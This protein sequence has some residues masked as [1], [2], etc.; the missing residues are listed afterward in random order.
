MQRLQTVASLHLAVSEARRAGHRVGL[1]PTMGALHDGHSTLIATAAKHCDVVITTLF[2]NP[3]QFGPT[4]DFS[5]YPRLL[6]ADAAIAERAGSRYLFCPSVEEMYPLGAASV[7]T[8]VTVRG[9]TDVLDGASRP[10]HFD[11]VATVVAKL[12]AMTGECT[13]FFGEKDFQQLAVVRRMAS[14]LSFPIQIVGVPTVREANGLA[15]SS[16]NRYLTAEQRDGASVIYQA[17]T[18]GRAAIDG[19]ASSVEA[20]CSLMR[21]MLQG[22]PVVD[23]IDYVA[24][25]NAATFE[26][27]EPLLGA[28][29]VRLLIACRVGRARLIDN[30]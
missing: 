3:L 18:A 23:S 9:I 13:A 7:L 5:A 24:C 15:M 17:L 1:V 14:D 11:G 6:D 16:R 12:F 2:V 22:S 25:V 29:Q 10:G 21:S 20:V 4:E 27:P 28:V 26:T 30:L 19:G 8:G